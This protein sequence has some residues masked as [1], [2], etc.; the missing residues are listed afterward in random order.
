MAGLQGVDVGRSVVLAH[1]YPLPHGIGVGLSVGELH[2]HLNAGAGLNNAVNGARHVGGLG[3]GGDPL[4]LVIPDGDDHLIPGTQLVKGAGLL[5]PGNVGQIGD[6]QLI[7][8]NHLNGDGGAVGDGGQGALHFHRALE[9]VQLGHHIAGDQSGD[10]PSGLHLIQRGAVA[11]IGDGGRLADGGGHGLAGEDIGN[12]HVLGSAGGAQLPHGTLNI[13]A[14]GV[15]RHKGGLIGLT[16]DAKLDILAHLSGGKGPQHPVHSDRHPG[17]NGV[18]IHYPVKSGDAQRGDPVGGGGNTLDQ[19][20]CLL[21]AAGELHP[22]Q[23]AGLIHIADGGGIARP[24][25]DQ[26]PAAQIPAH[27][28]LGKAV[29]KHGPGKAVDQNGKLVTLQSGDAAAIGGESAAQPGGLHGAPAVQVQP[30][31]LSSLQGIGIGQ[32]VVLIDF[33]TGRQGVGLG[34]VGQLVIKRKNNTLVGAAGHVGDGPPLPVVVGVLTQLHL[35]AGILHEIQSPAQHGGHLGSCHIAVGVLAVLGLG[36][37]GPKLV[38]LNDAKGGQH[39]DIGPQIGG[40][41]IRIGVIAQG[42]IGQALGQ[43]LQLHGPDQIHTDVFPGDGLEKGSGVRQRLQ[44]TFGEDPGLQRHRHL[45]PR[46]GDHAVGKQ[47]LHLLGMVGGDLLLKGGVHPRRPGAEQQCLSGGHLAVGLEGP[48]LV[49]LGIPQLGH[50]GHIIV[51]PVVLAHIGKGGVG[52]HHR[53]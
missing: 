14:G 37:E 9:A 24:L 35:N 33:H 25:V 42:I 49:S 7:G 21:G 18:L 48:V 27:G 31:I 43:R 19:P 39:I 17:G 47:F 44:L 4:H 45:S 13:V 3:G 50:G 16:V 12:G 22:R 29:H 20:L 38:P 46:P 32:H 34:L 52:R 8:Q 40:D 1:R 5:I 36:I 41:L 51:I 23:M 11:V 10:I 6:I 30:H 28:D 53:Q 26:L 15:H 2:L